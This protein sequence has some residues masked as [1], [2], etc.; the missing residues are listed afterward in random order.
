MEKYRGTIIEN[1]LKDKSILSELEIVNTRQ[2]DDWFLHDVLASEEQVKFLGR[3]LN[4]GPW[5]MHFWIPGQ[6]IAIVVFRDKN[7]EIKLSDKSTWAQ[8][9]SYGKSIGIPEEQLDF[10]T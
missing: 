8:A 4:C 5:Y 2:S 1:S 7:F 6:D 3:Y 9:V 10:L